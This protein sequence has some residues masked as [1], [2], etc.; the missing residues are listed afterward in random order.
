MHNFQISTLNHLGQG[1]NKI[2]EVAKGMARPGMDTQEGY[3]IIWA[4]T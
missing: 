4:D 3:D 1:P 2:T